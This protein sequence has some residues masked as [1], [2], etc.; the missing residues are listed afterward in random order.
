MKR[1]S[2]KHEVT[3]LFDLRNY[4]FLYDLPDDIFINHIMRRVRNLNK[5]IISLELEDEVIAEKIELCE[6]FIFDGDKFFTR[7]EYIKP[8]YSDEH[9]TNFRTIKPVTLNDVIEWSQSADEHTSFNGHS[10]SLRGL[11]K[12]ITKTI[13]DDSELIVNIN[14]NYSDEIIIYELRKA[15]STWR[16][17]I[18]ISESISDSSIHGW[19]I[20]KKKI[21]D[22][23]ILPLMDLLCWAKIKNLTMTNSLLASLLYEEHEYDTVN[24]AQTIKPFLEKT[25]LNFSI[26][27]LRKKINEEN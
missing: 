7:E 14:L 4:D 6:S 19:P 26:E 16:S 13:A 22:Y 21:M 15:I 5:G 12:S 18:G 3:E 2:K 27:S 25:V 11:K 17:E 20:L 24:L 1:I 9:L 23:K 8:P 10:R